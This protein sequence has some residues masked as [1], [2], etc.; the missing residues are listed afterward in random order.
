MTQNTQKASGEAYAFFDCN[1]SPK[2]IRAMIP[3]LR[4]SA[5]TPNKLELSLA[6]DASSLTQDSDLLEISEGLDYDYVMKAT[7]SGATNEE[8]AGEL[9]DIMNQAYQSP[10]YEKDEKFKGEVV[11]KS[12]NEYLFR[13]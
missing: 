2:K 11:Y 13:E 8:T 10:L 3:H 6:D 9:G 7:Y 4:D 5:Q 12:G 1:A